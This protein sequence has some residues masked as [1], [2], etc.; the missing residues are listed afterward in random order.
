MEENKISLTSLIASYKDAKIRLVKLT[1]MKT[2]LAI[3]DFC[4]AY[5]FWYLQSSIGSFLS[6]VFVLL[7]LILCGYQIVCLGLIIFNDIP[8]MYKLGKYIKTRKE[9]EIKEWREKN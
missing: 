5:L 4:L 8:Q 9:E 2:L 3:L 6:S 7:N 1:I